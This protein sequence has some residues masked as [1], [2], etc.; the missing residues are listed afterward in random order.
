MFDR[1]FMKLV[2]SIFAC[3]FREKKVG[4]DVTEPAG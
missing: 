2:F 4:P 3:F 1:F